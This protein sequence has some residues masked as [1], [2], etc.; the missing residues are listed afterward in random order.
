MDQY[1]SEIQDLRTEIDQMVE[2][3]EDPK[4]IADL[5]LQAQ[6]LEAIYGQATDLL[7]RGD[8]DPGLR[9]RLRVRGYGDWNLDNV[10]AFVYETATD[11]P[12]DG[13]QPFASE[14]RAA[15]FAAELTRGS[16]FGD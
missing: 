11:L 13:G 9:E 4:L 5:E 12:A 16:V 2:A 7:R 6:L 10:Y 3:E 15:D 14:I 8:E 1:Q